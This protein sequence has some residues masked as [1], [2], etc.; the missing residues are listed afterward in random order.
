MAQSEEDFLR[1]F[2]NRNENPELDTIPA[3][4][5]SSGG[6]RRPNMRDRIGRSIRPQD[7]HGVNTPGEAGVRRPAPFERAMGP[8]TPGDRGA[9][10]QAD[11]SRA[12]RLQ[13]IPPSEAYDAGRERDWRQPWMKG[14]RR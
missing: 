9:G 11:P 6:V 13:A 5:P 8:H 3:Q 1:R 4:G 12:G 14:Q 7:V 10:S 2:L